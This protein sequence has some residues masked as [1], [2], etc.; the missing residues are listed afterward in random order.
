MTNIDVTDTLRLKGV[1]NK[2]SLV[3]LVDSDSTH[4][5]IWDAILPRLCLRALLGDD[6]SVK[7]ANDEKVYNGGICANMA[8]TIGDEE[9]KADY[10][11]LPLD[12]MDLVF[13]VA[14]LRSLG[15]ILCN[16]DTLTMTFWRQGH[17]V[18]WN[19]LGGIV[20]QLASMDM[21]HKL[22]GTLLEILLRHL[23]RATGTSSSTMPSSPHPSIARDN[24]CGHSFL[25]LPAVNQR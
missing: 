25:L 20:G 23:H 1:I 2:V 13:R 6:L 17:L 8:L 16:Y 3:T 14:L 4:T 7:V 12:G 9:F 18:R 10:Y 24:A 11:V 22:V 5:F 19:D 15:P 21:S